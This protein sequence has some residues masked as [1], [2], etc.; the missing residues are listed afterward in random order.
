MSRDYLIRLRDMLAA[1]ERASVYGS[2][3]ASAG[4]LL[5][6]R[7]ILDAILFNLFVL[8]EAAKGVPEEVRSRYSGVQWKAMAG[9]RDVLA[10]EYFGVDTDVVWDVVRAEL[11]HLIEQLRSIIAEE[12]KEQGPAK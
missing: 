9:L 2:G 6:N 12:E 5:A 10:H 4:A 8:G 11:P 1:A 7:Q 3:V